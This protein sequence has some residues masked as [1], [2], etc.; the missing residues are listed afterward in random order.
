M[1]DQRQGGGVAGGIVGRARPAL[2]A[3]VVRLDIG[4]A[5]GQ[6]DAVE[7]LQ[8]PVEGFGRGGV[9]AEFRSDGRDQHRQGADGTDYRLDVLVTHGVMPATPPV[10]LETGGNA[11]ERPHN[12]PIHIRAKS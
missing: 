1:P 2:L 11:D 10:L 7:R 3:V 8:Q 12:R 9:I 4:G 6:Q 5:A